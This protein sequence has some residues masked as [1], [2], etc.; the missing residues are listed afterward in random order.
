MNEIASLTSGSM[1]SLPRSVTKPSI[2]VFDQVNKTLSFTPK[3][4]YNRTHAR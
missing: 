2:N 3:I 1:N 4:S